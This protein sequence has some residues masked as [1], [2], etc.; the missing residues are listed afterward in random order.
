[1]RKILLALVLGSLLMIV[2]GCGIIK[3]YNKPVFEEI[4]PHQTAFV[5]PLEGKTDEQGQFESEGF[6]EDNQVATKR[7]QVSRTWYRTG[8]LP[9][10]GSYKPDVRVIVVDRFPETREWLSDKERGTS[11]KSE[12][13]VGESKDSIKFRVGF[14]A[15]ASIEEKDAAKFLYKYNNKTLK[16]VMDFEVRN[17]IG[18]VLL[19]KYGSM[20]MKEIREDKEG[21]IKHVRKEV[22]PF[23][24]DMGIT[25]SNLGYVGDLDYVDEDVQ[26]AINEQFKAQEEQ[27][28]QE[29][30]NE[31]EIKKA[32]AEQEAIKK[33]E[34]TLDETI[35]LREL[36]IQQDW[37]KKWDG[38]AP[39]VMSGADG[40]EN[41]LFSV[42][43]FK[44]KEKKKDK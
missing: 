3:P 10:S 22:T 34:T 12:G 19:E 2:S 30:R 29:I 8:R 44:E 1:M 27:K 41:F 24:K 11:E 28:A 18:T 4:E 9:G 38:E 25:I 15:T 17:R 36:E 21:V 14:S 43:K 23:F 40:G 35:K 33:R 6:L 26:K 13:F 31:T 7:I 32:T 39:S 37:I 42:D 16:E 20:S 5:I